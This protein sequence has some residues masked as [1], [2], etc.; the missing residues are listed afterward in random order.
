MSSTPK[1]LPIAKVNINTN[2]PFNRIVKYPEGNI[3]KY[4]EGGSITA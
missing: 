2:I 1:H 4:A 3:N